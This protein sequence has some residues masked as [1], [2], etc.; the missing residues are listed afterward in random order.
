M[1]D[2]SPPPRKVYRFKPTEFENVNDVRRD[3]P[4]S[5]HET[6]PRPDPGIVPTDKVRIDVRDLAR[7]AMIPPA[8]SPPAPARTNEVHTLLRDNAARAEAAGLNRLAEKPR[9]R[10]RRKRD[11]AIAMILGNAVLLMGTAIMPLFGIV[12]LIIYNLG[13]TWI[14]WFVMDDY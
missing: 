5:L 12:G 9:R 4:L 8:A 11:Y 1:P 10:S 6:Q 3:E 7:A 2:A 13:L 14:M